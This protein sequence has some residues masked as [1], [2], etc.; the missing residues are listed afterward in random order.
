LINIVDNPR[1]VAI[2][3]TTSVSSRAQNKIVYRA[4]PYARQNDVSRTGLFTLALVVKSTAP[5]EVPQVGR[6][7]Q[8]RQ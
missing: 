3:I 7:R 5:D 8:S 6:R 2:G 4:R 1:V